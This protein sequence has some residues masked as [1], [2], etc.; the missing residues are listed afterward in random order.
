MSIVWGEKSQQELQNKFIAR[1]H[2]YTF[3]WNRDFIADEKS[4]CFQGNKHS[5]VKD[6]PCPRKNRQENLPRLQGQKLMP[7]LLMPL[8][9]GRGAGM[10]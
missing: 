9:L 6:W 10:C 4:Y 5:E 8:E 1:K 3:E 2:R 7:N